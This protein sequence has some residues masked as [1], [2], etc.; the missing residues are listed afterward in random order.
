MQDIGGSGSSFSAGTHVIG[1]QA[2]DACGNSAFCEFTITI[3][4]YEGGGGGTDCSENIAGFEYLGMLNNHAYYLSLD[5]TRAADAQDIATSNG[6][7]LAVINTA[8]ENDFLYSHINQMTY[9]GLNDAATE[10]NLSW[11]N[12]DAVSYNNFD[13]CSFC[14]DN[15]AGD[16]YVVMHPWNGGWS[17]SNRWSQRPFLMEVPC[18]AGIQLPNPIMEAQTTRLS[19]LSPNPATNQIFVQV[20]ASQAIDTPILIFDAMGRKV[21]EQQVQLVGGNN[22]L[23]F[24]VSYLPS[25]IYHV[26]MPKASVQHRSL[27]FVKQGL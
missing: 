12:G 10:G 6:G 14:F 2:F 24:N 7:Y 25:G 11:V 23:D 4:P 1:Y 16:D 17:Y 18:A 22:Y 8:A 26:L 20:E 21:M 5:A 15:S 9:L 3:S 13:I 19:Q 27:R